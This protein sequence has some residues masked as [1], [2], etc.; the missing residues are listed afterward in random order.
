MLLFLE[1]IKESPAKLT[2]LIIG[3]CL[4]AFAIAGICLSIKTI[5]NKI[6]R[7]I[8]LLVLPVLTLTDWFGFLFVSVGLFSADVALD[9]LLAFGIALVAVVAAIGVAFLFCRNKTEKA[10]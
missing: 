1:G 8:F 4:I 9:L 10:E 3:I 7:I 6:F 5:S 2:L